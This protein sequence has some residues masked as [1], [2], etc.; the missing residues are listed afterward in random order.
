VIWAVWHGGEPY[1]PGRHGALQ[2]L[3]AADGLT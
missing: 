2:R 1:D 3:L